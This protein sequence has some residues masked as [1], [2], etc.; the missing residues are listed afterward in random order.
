[1]SKIIEPN[2]IIFDTSQLINLFNK[3]KISHLNEHSFID[4]YGLPFIFL[5]HLIE[6]SKIDDFEK[7]SKNLIMLE[8]VEVF[9]TLN[10]SDPSLPGSI[11]DILIYEIFLTY[12]E[13]VISNNE[14][15]KNIIKNSCKFKLNI[16]IN[17]HFELYNQLRS[18]AN[19]ESLMSILLNGLTN[20]VFYKKISTLQ[21]DNTKIIT[22]DNIETWKSVYLLLNTR[23]KNT[24]EKDKLLME[25]KNIEKNNEKIKITAIEAIEKLTRQKADPDLTSEDMFY[26]G[27]FSDIK[28][29]ASEQYKIDIEK[30]QKIN[31]RDLL[32]NKVYFESLR[33]LSSILIK[34]K[35]RKIESSNIFDIYFLV[36]SIFFKVFVDIRTYDLGTQLSKKFNME[37]NIDKIFDIAT[38]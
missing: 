38:V 28:I 20:E 13:G 22:M 15:R 2:Y 31:Y 12:K 10:S 1:M 36:C 11:L 17:K 35:K 18:L 37:L 7:F 6:L 30:F 29:M 19:K 8:N 24:K 32:A 4:K 23:L 33:C 27:L 3:K 21:A 34:D 26:N 14:L 9:L 5:E 25:F 16:P